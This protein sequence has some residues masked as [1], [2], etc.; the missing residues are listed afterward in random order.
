MPTDALEEWRYSRIGDLDLDRYR[1]ADAGGEPSRSGAEGLLDALGGAALVVHT[2]DGR[3]AGT[4]TAQDVEVSD[5][6]SG[7]TAPQ[8]NPAAD[9]D[10][11]ST[12]NRAF[13]PSWL[14]VRAAPGARAG[15]VVLVHHVSDG[16]VAVFPRV[17][18]EAGRGAELNVVEMIVGGSG[19][20]V[21][22]V[23]VLHADDAAH[24][25]YTQ[26]QLLD[27]SAWQVASQSSFVGRDA[28]LVSAAVALGGDYA[29]LR[30]ASSLVAP[31]ANG[32]L[33]ALYFGAGSQMHDFR[34]VQHHAAPKTQSELVYKGVV[35][36]ESHS[37][38]S[39]LI[40]VDKG[41]GGTNAMQTN[42]NLVLNEGAHA[43][44]V[45][46]LEIEDNDVRCSHAS[47]V[48][49]IADDQRFYLESRGV[50][51]RVAERLIALGF[52][53]DLLEQLPVKE[54]APT[55]RSMLASKL[56]AVEHAPVEVGA[57]G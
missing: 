11:Y 36:N 33:L 47:A 41:A 7:G 2:Y 17:E 26:L 55:L 46:N 9:P 14:I 34:T 27:R 39:G 56:G 3:A 57:G 32:K 20:F 6:A 53:D 54:L 29:R 19:G 18:V 31:G 48:G 50:P 24:L 1:V 8:L 15:T 13:A 38:Y 10:P 49:P 45:P 40:R 16:P 52:M 28:S 30:T 42:R 5:V 51:T 12:L 21:A 4:P 43:D 22:P 37:V 25:S 44:S 35:A 23:T